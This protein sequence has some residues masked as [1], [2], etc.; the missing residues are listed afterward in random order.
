MYIYYIYVYMTMKWSFLMCLKTTGEG[1]EYTW[2]AGVS[3]HR[4]VNGIRSIRGLIDCECTHAYY[5]P[6]NLPNLNAA[7]SVA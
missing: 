4:A 6:N 3:V 7:S 1:K 5:G 2:W